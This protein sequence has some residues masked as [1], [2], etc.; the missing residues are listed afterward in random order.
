M[1]G[2]VAVHALERLGWRRETP[3]PSPAGT[4]E[5]DEPAPR[6]GGSNRLDRRPMIGLGSIREQGEL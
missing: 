1:T 2:I 6:L 5:P 3:A 4:N